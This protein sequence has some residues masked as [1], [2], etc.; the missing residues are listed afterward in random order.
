MRR[1]ND[2]VNMRLLENLSAEVKNPKTF[3]HY[4]LDVARFATWAKDDQGLRIFTQ[5]EDPVALL[6]TYSE[7]LQ[8]RGLSANTIHSYL[9]PVCKGLG[10]NMKHVAKPK[11]SA[12]TV[13]KTRDPEKG[14]RGRDDLERQRENRVVVAQQAI[15]IRKS[16]LY[17]LRGAD[18]RT[19]A[20]GHL[21]VYVR[22]G[23]GGKRQY[24]RILPQDVETVKAIFDGIDTEKKVF[25]PDE[26][27]ATKKIALHA[28]RAEHARE[29]YAYYNGIIGADPRQRDRLRTELID[30]YK[31]Y[32]PKGNDPEAVARFTALIDKGNG[33][34]KLR[35]DNKMAFTFEGRPITY[36]RVA[37]MAV[38][39][40][41]LSHWRLDVTIKHYMR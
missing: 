1:T 24:Q 5:I 28:L 8:E 22:K 4:K 35:G 20:F 16:E 29:A 26:I 23:K 36:D 7:H 25:S 38:S 6:T 32:N 34:Y 13:T 14:Q 2:T 12:L 27:Q 21:C 18:L 41:H 39:V 15:G 30:T 19:D 9:A 31:A 33:V 40:W 3:R 11:R 37:L 17:K 10:I